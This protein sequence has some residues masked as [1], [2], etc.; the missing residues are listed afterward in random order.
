MCYHFGMP[1]CATSEVEKHDVIVFVRMLW[2]LERFGVF[3]SLLK[4]LKTFGCFIPNT[5][6]SFK[7]RAFLT[8]FQNM[9][10]DYGLTCTYYHFDFSRVTTIDYIFLSK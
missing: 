8:C 6:N 5:N 1:R 4:I 2:T 10:N 7:S 9:P 3:Y